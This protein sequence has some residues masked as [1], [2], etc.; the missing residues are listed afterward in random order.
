MRNLFPAGTE[1][2]PIWQAKD[3]REGVRRRHVQPGL[4]YSSP[5]KANFEH[6]PRNMGEC[7]NFGLHRDLVIP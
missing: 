7:L 1:H 4:T 3:G 5:Q 2:V 6:E